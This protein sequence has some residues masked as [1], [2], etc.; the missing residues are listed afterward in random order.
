MKHTCGDDGYEE[1]KIHGTRPDPDRPGWIRHSYFVV[2][3]C[4]RCDKL[5]WRRQG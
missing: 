3:Y 2:W 4:P 5:F 1:T